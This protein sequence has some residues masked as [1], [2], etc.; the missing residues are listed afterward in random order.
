MPH[1]WESLRQRVLK[2]HDLLDQP[3]FQESSLVRNFGIQPLANT[4]PTIGRSGAEV[5]Q[6]LKRESVSRLENLPLT[7]QVITPSELTASKAGDMFAATVIKVEDADTVKVRFNGGMEKSVRLLGIDT[8]ETTHKDPRLNWRQNLQRTI[9][10]PGQGLIGH[11]ATKFLSNT[12]LGKQILLERDV[13]LEDRYE[14]VLGH[15]HLPGERGLTNVNALL[16]EKGYAFRYEGKEDMSRHVGTMNQA[17]VNAAAA[18]R[19]VYDPLLALERPSEYKHHIKGT[20]AAPAYAATRFARDSMYQLLRRGNE[21][22][23]PETMAPRRLSLGTPELEPYARTI[24]VSGHQ[25][26]LIV[27]PMIGMAERRLTYDS[28]AA[29]LRREGYAKDAG[30]ANEAYSA[31]MQ[32]NLQHGRGIFATMYKSAY[33]LNPMKP[34]NTYGDIPVPETV[35]AVDL[36]NVALP[37]GEQW[38]E[39]KMAQWMGRMMGEDDVTSFRQRPGRGMFSSMLLGSVETAERRYANFLETEAITNKYRYTSKDEPATPVT[40]LMENVFDGLYNLVMLNA[41]YSTVLRPLTHVGASISRSLM[42]VTSQPGT[43]FSGLL[44][45]GLNAV[46]VGGTIASMEA[47]AEITPFHPVAPEVDQALGRAGPGQTQTQRAQTALQAAQRGTMIGVRASQTMRTAGQGGNLV[48][49]FL[50]TINRATMAS[51]V[52][53]FASIFRG[54]LQ[55]GPRAGFTQLMQATGGFRG[56]LRYGSERALMAALVVGTVRSLMTDPTRAPLTMAGYRQFEDDLRGATRPGDPLPLFAYTPGANR[57]SRRLGWGSTLGL[58]TLGLGLTVGVIRRTMAP[59]AI[60]ILAAIAGGL[61]DHYRPALPQAGDTEV[62]RIGLHLFGDPYMAGYEPATRTA[63]AFLGSGLGLRISAAGEAM[64]R[65]RAG[66]ALGGAVVGALAGPEVVGMI[67]HSFE[68]YIQGPTKTSYEMGAYDVLDLTTSPAAAA[69]VGALGFSLGMM[70]TSSAQATRGFSPRARLLASYAAGGILGTAGLFSNWLLAQVAGS[71]YKSSHVSGYGRW[72]HSAGVDWRAQMTNAADM[73]AM[74]DAGPGYDAEVMKVMMLQRE[75]VGRDKGVSM[76]R[77]YVTQIGTP[78]TGVAFFGVRDTIKEQFQVDRQLIWG[79]QGPFHLGVGVSFGSPYVLSSTRTPDGIETWRMKYTP[80]T[81]A[82]GAAVLSTTPLVALPLV[83]SAMRNYARPSRGGALGALRGMVTMNP[84][85]NPVGAAAFASQWLFRSVSIMGRVALNPQ[86]VPGHFGPARGAFQHAKAIGGLQTAGMLAYMGMADMWVSSTD[87]SENVDAWR[88]RALTVSRGIQDRAGQYLTASSMV[89]GALS[90]R[91]IANAWNEAASMPR[92]RMVAAGGGAIVGA[93]VGGVVANLLNTNDFYA[94]MMNLFWGVV[95]QPHRFFSP[96]TSGA[97]NIGKFVG[98]NPDPFSLLNPATWL[99][100]TTEAG[101]FLNKSAK[102]DKRPTMTYGARLWEAAN[103]LFGRSAYFQPT[104]PYAGISIFGV[105]IADS[106]DMGV[107]LKTLYGQMTT[108]LADVTFSETVAGKEGKGGSLEDPVSLQNWARLQLGQPLDGVNLIERHGHRLSDVMFYSGSGLSEASPV[109]RMALQQRLTTHAWLLNAHGM[110]AARYMNVGRAMTRL[111]RSG[112]ENALTWQMQGASGGV[113][114]MVPLRIN[115]GPIGKGLMNRF[116]AM[117]GQQYGF[118][119]T[120]EFDASGLADADAAYQQALQRSDRSLGDA[121]TAR[122]NMWQSQRRPEWATGLMLTGAIGLGVLARHFVRYRFETAQRGWRFA[123]NTFDRFLDRYAGGDPGQIGIIRGQVLSRNRRLGS[124][125]DVGDGAARRVDMRWHLDRRV[126]MTWL[127]Y[128]GGIYGVADDALGRGGFGARSSGDAERLTRLMRG[129]STLNAIE[130]IAERFRMLDPRGAGTIDILQRDLAALDDLLDRGQS[131][132]IGGGRTLRDAVRGLRTQPGQT[133][134][135]VRTILRHAQRYVSQASER[136]TQIAGLLAWNEN[137][138]MMTAEPTL[139]TQLGSEQRGLR[140]LWSRFRFWMLV[141]PNMRVAELEREAGAHVSN[142]QRVMNLVHVRSENLLTFM[143][144]EVNRNRANPTGMMTTVDTTVDR[145]QGMASRWLSRASRGAELAVRG[146]LWGA[147]TA[148]KGWMTFTQVAMLF[149]TLDRDNPYRQ[150]DMRSLAA[151]T[152]AFRYFPMLLSARREARTLMFA[153]ERGLTAVANRIGQI[154]FA[155]LGSRFGQFRLGLGMAHDQGLRRGLGLGARLNQAAQPGVFHR[156]A[157]GA[158]RLRAGFRVAGATAAYPFWRVGA[159]AGTVVDGLSR[160]LLGL[161]QAALRSPLGWPARYADAVRYGYESGRR[162]AANQRALPLA[163]Q[164]RLA[165]G[166][167]FAHQ[168]VDQF[169]STWQATSLARAEARIAAYEAQGSARGILDWAGYQRARMVQNQLL[170]VPGARPSGIGRVAGGRFG[171][172]M[173]HFGLPMVAFMTMD[174]TWLGKKLIDADV[175]AQ[176]KA[177]RGL[178]SNTL[179]GVMGGAFYYGFNFTSMLPVFTS[180][181]SAAV[182]QPVGAAASLGVGLLGSIFAGFATSALAGAAHLS[183]GA[184]GTLT[185]IPNKLLVRA[186]KNQLAA[187]EMDTTALEEQTRQYEKARSLYYRGKSPDWGPTLTGVVGAGLAAGALAL[188]VPGAGLVAL[189]GVAAAGGGLGRLFGET[190]Y[191][192]SWGEAIAFNY[193]RAGQFMSS[194]WFGTKQSL[195]MGLGAYTRQLTALTGAEL[196]GRSLSMKLPELRRS[197]IFHGYLTDYFRQARDEQERL[198]MA[199]VGMSIYH[200]LNPMTLGSYMTGTG[201]EDVTQADLPGRL[202]GKPEGIGVG[203]IGASRIADEFRPMSPFEG[204][205]ALMTAVKVRA[206][207]TDSWAYGQAGLRKETN[208][209]F[210]S[211]SW[212][213][214]PE[215]QSL[216]NFGNWTMGLGAA[217]VVTALGLAVSAPLAATAVPVGAVA[218]GVVGLGLAAVGITST[219]MAGV[220]SG[221]TLRSPGSDVGAVSAPVLTNA[222][223]GGKDFDLRR[224]AQKA[225][226]AAAHVKLTGTLG[227]APKPIRKEEAPAPL[228]RRKLQE[229]ESTQVA[230]AGQITSS[231][232]FDRP[233]EKPLADDILVQLQ[234]TLKTAY[235]SVLGAYQTSGVRNV[236]NG[237]ASFFSNG[238]FSA[239]RAPADGHAHHGEVVKNG[240]LTSGFGWRIH[241]IT[242]NARMHYGQ[243]IA[244]SKGHAFFARLGGVVT[245]AGAAGGYGRLITIDHGGGLVTRYGH[246]DEAVRVGQRVSRGQQIGWVNTHGGSTGPHVHF[247]VMINGQ[248]VNP[249][250][251]E[252]LRA[253]NSRLQMEKKD[254][255]QAVRVAPM[256]MM[257]AHK[258]TMRGVSHEHKPQIQGPPSVDQLGPGGYGPPMAPGRHPAQP[259]MQVEGPPRLI[260]AIMGASKHSHID[261]NILTSQLKAES[262][263]NATARSGVGAVGIAQFMPDTARWMGL[264]VDRTVDE[265]LDPNKSIA[266]QGRYM[267]YLYNLMGKHTADHGERV[268]L[269]LAAYNAGEGRVQRDILRAGAARY[270]KIAP[271]LPAETQGYVP[272]ILKDAAKGGKIPDVPLPAS[273]TVT[274]TTLAQTPGRKVVTVEIPENTNHMREG[275]YDTIRRQTEDRIPGVRYAVMAGAVV[276]TAKGRVVDQAEALSANAAD[277]TPYVD[278]WKAAADTSFRQFG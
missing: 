203:G 182:G 101:V 45:R 48:A 137:S 159:A 20:A 136:A 65:H 47:V 219:I 255:K 130:D 72:L 254:S 267:G 180:L 278:A 196:G 189:A 239:P 109:V 96:V 133:E 25:G 149:P 197:P 54:G 29:A 173:L 146:S 33:A 26:R 27:N 83:A 220:S 19:G 6:Q 115:L 44:S 143:R 155:Q 36:H 253:I 86:T 232:L 76:M 211:Q 71:E 187:L 264:R 74:R 260:D 209:D 248:F 207:L 18:R 222:L 110:E 262:N 52:R 51:K 151:S 140:G 153:T 38:N 176:E 229:D 266:A 31:V 49:R 120:S 191:G 93:L 2:E 221:G 242:G 275:A 129:Q 53:D 263:F 22:S 185:P 113:G 245:Q 91:R 102:I 246:G 68:R 228:R 144:D 1:D 265:R 202:F 256:P 13:L 163:R 66:L 94:K 208:T 172:G 252:A 106:P 274:A 24:G 67:R 88:G 28:L 272:K 75:I 50:S 204:T 215:V 70:L 188:L 165:Y 273:G 276:Y 43:G 42:T 59:G 216:R 95:L 141:E 77:A 39:S 128:K 99:D 277:T 40:G 241:P 131:V 171:A 142:R 61:Y 244:D 158:G 167:G 258:P 250:G 21:L 108:G 12:V 81:A 193:R 35:K 225:P 261:P 84:M 11:E 117:L 138:L 17:A 122:Y 60:G 134:Q 85:I 164:N 30:S 98:R 105:K 119:D 181:A 236:V 224:K 23:N 97:V 210:T 198:R 231:M 156:A 79:F 243:D 150:E 90:G 82:E 169:F 104:D 3:R 64:R 10:D 186:A 121:V 78:L 179:G 125:M 270:D 183:M 16:L 230:Y 168:R 259:K 116:N 177:L 132:D 63:M 8:P 114:N 37:G 107:F 249:Q 87:D 148:F 92:R 57:E 166:A 251:P 112:M 240:V 56:A 160:G 237:I 174:K 190:R 257:V 218:A 69:T 192:A 154:Q 32:A 103:N 55:A 118:A 46:M 5:A 145:A 161:G 15:I 205:E 127:E 157:Y 268:K 233:K 213:S 234:N 7:N 14:R 62:N 184:I 199:P 226:F 9:S 214:N 139:S 162:V 175:W 124:V 194:L 223:P 195:R 235:H 73:M 100:P 123:S 4:S 135:E 111:R 89:L 201:Y 238:G 126:T 170:R 212:L 269:A 206:G 271:Y 247:E 58:G 217:G 34:F 178:E 147:R 152:W 200:M 227:M 80:H 41:L